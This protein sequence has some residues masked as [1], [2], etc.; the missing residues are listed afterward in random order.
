MQTDTAAAC[1]AG[2]VLRARP[3]HNRAP[4]VALLNSCPYTR[5]VYLVALLPS[6]LTSTR[7]AK[8]HYLAI[9]P[10]GMESAPIQQHGFRAWTKPVVGN[11]HP[12]AGVLCAPYTL[13]SRSA[14]LTPRW[15]HAALQL[16]RLAHYRAKP[17]HVVMTGSTMV[18]RRELIVVALAPLALHVRRVGPS[19]PPDLWEE[20]S[21]WY[22]TELGW[23]THAFRSLLL[24][25]APLVLGSP[26]LNAEENAQHS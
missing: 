10:M 8:Q 12:Q 13:V 18:Q 5:R 14:R 9:M 20:T 24:A 6:W 17:A 16:Q 22:A 23:A 15:T 11:I 4:L 21:P 25:I 3:Y 2:V 7:C 1:R 19:K 26:L